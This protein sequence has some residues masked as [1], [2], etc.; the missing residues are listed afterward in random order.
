[1]VCESS[2]RIH[3]KQEHKFIVFLN[4]NI[5]YNKFCAVGAAA[6]Y[7]A[8]RFLPLCVCF[9]Q[10]WYHPF[11][12]VLF[13]QYTSSFRREDTQQKFSSNK[14][15]QRSEETIKIRMRFVKSEDK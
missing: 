15:V 1:M 4:Y 2:E 11:A 6:M 5:N 14:I 13:D 9:L 8:F 7:S 10:Q 3:T 12:V